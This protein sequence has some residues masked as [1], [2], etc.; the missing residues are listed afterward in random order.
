[1]FDVIWVELSVPIPTVS[2]F[3]VFLYWFIGMMWACWRVFVMGIQGD[4]SNRRIWKDESFLRTLLIVFFGV[5]LWVY[6]I[7]FT[8]SGL[9]DDD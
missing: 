8:K 4:Q 2:F 3:P 6:L 5:L 7:T 9:F 1:M